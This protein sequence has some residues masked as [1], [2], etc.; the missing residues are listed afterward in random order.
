MGSTTKWRAGRKGAIVPW[1][2]EDTEAGCLHLLSGVLCSQE[3]VWK[4][5]EMS[6]AMSTLPSQTPLPTLS[7][8]HKAHYSQEGQ[9]SKQDSKQTCSWQLHEELRGKCG[10]PRLFVL[11]STMSRSC[12]RRTSLKIV[13]KWLPTQQYDCIPHKIC[14]TLFICCK[15]KN[16]RNTTHLKAELQII[17]IIMMY[18]FTNISS[19]S[20]LRGVP[21]S[22]ALRRCYK[23]NHRGSLLTALRVGLQPALWECLP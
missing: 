12:S 4:G 1:G 23:A 2:P 14:F 22:I 19:L 15:W 16:I 6:K 7:A 18:S 20:T 17:I 11:C 9:N 10:L 13:L 8:D 3:G 21:L 5:T